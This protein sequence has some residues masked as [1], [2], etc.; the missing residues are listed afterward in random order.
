[1]KKP[2]HYLYYI[3]L[4]E[5]GGFYADVRGK[6]GKTVL[7]I[8]GGN[9]LPEGESSLVDDG[10]MRNFRDIDGLRDYMRSIGFSVASLNFGN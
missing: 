1:M 2:S 3:N 4:D 5:R 6:N 8:R 9:E 10:F 7:E